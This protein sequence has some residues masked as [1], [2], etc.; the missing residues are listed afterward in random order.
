MTF[1]AGHAVPAMHESEKSG[2]LLLQSIPEYPSSTLQNLSPGPA[3]YMTLPVAPALGIALNP[4]AAFYPAS[5]NTV[6]AVQ[7]VNG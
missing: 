4:S 5:N 7:A 1:L 6:L 2:R 3:A